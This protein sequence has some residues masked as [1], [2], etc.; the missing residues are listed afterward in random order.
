MPFCSF[1][2]SGESGP[3]PAEAS[4]D[5]KVKAKIEPAMTDQND[6]N[7]QRR[8][9]ADHALGHDSVCQQHARRGERDP[10][11]GKN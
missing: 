1:C 4:A 11:P 10:A 9:D 8:A 7:R 2:A 5:S 3:V 6:A